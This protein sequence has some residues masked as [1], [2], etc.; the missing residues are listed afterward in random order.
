MEPWNPLKETLDD[1]ATL[2]GV[3]IEATEEQLRAAYLEQVCQHPPDRDPDH[4]ERIRDAYDRLRDPRLR[5]QQVLSGPDP[6]APLTKLLE[7]VHPRRKFVG[8]GPWLDVLK[9][10]R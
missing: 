9:E 1:A 5:A 6:A 7:G 8:P 3:S 4:F 10:K 2:L